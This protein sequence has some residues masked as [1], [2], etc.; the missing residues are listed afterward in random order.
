LLVAA[1][2]AAA[3][4]ALGAAPAGAKQPQPPIIM[5]RSQ[6]EV[7][8]LALND[9]HGNLLPPGGSGGRVGSTVAGG[10]AYLATHIKS[11]E[12]T[13]ANTIVVSAGDLVGASPLLS[14]L[15]HDEPTIEAMNEIG[16]DL[17]AVG[18]HEFDEGA[19]ELLRLA[20]GGCHPTDGCQD[21]TPFDGAD[22]DFLAANV[23]ETA[24]GE[25]IFAPYSIQN[26]NGARVAFIG[27]TLEG[28]PII[29]SAAGIQGLEFRDE[30][31]TVNALIPEL[32][33]QGVEAVVVLVHEGGTPTSLDVN[34]CSGVS[35]PILDIV[36][37]LDAEVDLVVSG[38]THQPYSCVIDGI[39]TTSAYSFGRIV[40]DID[41]RVDRRTRDVTGLTVNNRIITRD[42]P[43]D[44]GIVDL[45]DRYSVVAAPI[46]N[47]PIGHITAD[48]LNAAQP[49]G[50]QV[51][52]NVIAD[53]QLAATA[54]PPPQG[55][56]VVAFM[57]P[58]GVR[59]G[60]TYLSGLAGEGDGVV[61]FGEAFTVQPFGNILQTLSLTGAQIDLMLEQQFCGVNSPWAPT[62]GFFKVLLPSSGFAYTWDNAVA[63]APTNVTCA[64]DPA[65][66]AVDP[67]DVSLNGV[68]LDLAAAYR[69]T[70]NSF[71]AD[72]GDGFT[73]LRS[74]TDR[75]GGL[76]DLQAFEAYLAGAEPTGIAPP[77]LDRITRL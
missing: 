42:V 32:R 59:A 63:S 29:V 65:L 48:L 25:T 40:T 4:V 11:L 8:V 77:A 23:V 58:G 33:R 7:Q 22:F 54:G 45:I 61:T 27:M 18:N 30:A 56:S 19:T 70:V 26:F 16:L 60:L 9:F 44:Q 12:A 36:S 35:G 10:A 64:T 41:L 47:R 39:P 43:A 37:R 34:E 50:E 17:N 66:G 72:G 73:V 68:P 24:S 2:I 14:A 74:G 75:V 1:A 52:G 51:M 5:D 20:E 6:V 62:P 28:T 71:L 67:S 15:F 13:N 31:D 38:H 69:V 21:G 3:A 76:E 46:A 49:D 57:N 53:A 55:E